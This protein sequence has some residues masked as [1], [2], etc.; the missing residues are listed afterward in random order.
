VRKSAGE[1]VTPADQKLLED[2]ASQAGLVL[3]NVRLIEEL[4]GSRQR[5]VT[6][7]DEERRRLERDLHDGAQQRLVAISL[8][9]RMAGGLV[10]PEKEGPL[11]ER[12]DQASE[13]LSVALSELREFARGVHPAILTER[14][15]V[16]ALQ[17]LAERS[18]VPTSVDAS[19]DG[20]LPPAVEATAYFVVSEALANVGKYS[21]ATEVAIQVGAHDGELR[22]DVADDG[23]GGADPSQ[24]SGLRGLADRVAAVDGI[25]EI[26]SPPGRGTRLTVR[27]PVPAFA[28]VTA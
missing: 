1:A 24:G 17:S 6:A 2:L 3:R 25:F 28:E 18:T 7:Q 16:P 22:V 14:G 20:R 27:I 8:A 10:N 5:L 13:E 19:V 26:E 12:L 4:R 11:G 9:L 15:L 21:Q 23:V